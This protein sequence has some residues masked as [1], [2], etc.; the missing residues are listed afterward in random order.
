MATRE[1]IKKAILGAV[2]NPSAGVIADNV[3][4]MV[5]AVAELDVVKPKRE[6]DQ[7]ET[8][9]VEPKETR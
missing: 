5:D 3:D 6:F 9:K 4:R 1:E 7:R 2:G 8:R